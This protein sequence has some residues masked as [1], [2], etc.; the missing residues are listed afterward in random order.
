MGRQESEPPFKRRSLKQQKREFKSEAK[1]LK[2]HQ[3][4]TRTETPKA[5]AETPEPRI[6]TPPPQ[7]RQEPDSTSMDIDQDPIVSAEEPKLRVETDDEKKARKKAR[8]VA[9]K[10]AR[11]TVVKTETFVP[12]PVIP[13]SPE[14]HAP[15]A[16]K[17]LASSS[18]R[19]P[20][21]PQRKLT[22]GVVSREGGGLM[23]QLKTEQVCSLSCR[24]MSNRFSEST[25]A[26]ILCCVLVTC[27]KPH[28][29]LT[30]KIT[31]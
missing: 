6:D 26:D 13:E 1:W 28:R 10:R 22:D 3:P 27:R 15:A 19:M 21:F 11:A 18:R 12:P 9:K 14:K 29:R 23:Q 31:C 16:I 2:Q 25:V 5:H 8:K 30:R 24:D 4:Q 7:H 17:E 20:S